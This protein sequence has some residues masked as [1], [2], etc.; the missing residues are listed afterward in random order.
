L[1]RTI[2]RARALHAPPAE[3]SLLASALLGCGGSGGPALPVRASLLALLAIAFATGLTHAATST[4]PPRIQFV[5]AISIDYASGKPLR[6]WENTC[7]IVQASLSEWQGA[8]MTQLVVRNPAPAGLRQLLRQLPGPETGTFQVIYLAARHTPEGAW[9]FTQA[10]DGTAS[11]DDLLQ[12]PPPAHA[13][14]LVILDV[15]HAGVVVDQPVWQHNLAPAATLLASARD[16][17]TYEFDFSNC[18]PID[19]SARYPAAT[20]WLRRNLP[21]DWD[22]RLSNLGLAWA[23]AFQ[24]TLQPPQSLRD[25]QVFF[26]CCENE[27]GRLR[28]MLGTK[29]AS[30]VSQSPPGPR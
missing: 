30:T 15:C 4:P 8:P 22:G 7:R 14:R 19:L 27:A 23:I 5:A 18:Q 21:Q 11:W 17:L 24:Q 28:K 13:G 9:K 10:L 29:Y 26:G 16:E 20:A 1:L 2:G 12:H 6:G 25:W 3:A